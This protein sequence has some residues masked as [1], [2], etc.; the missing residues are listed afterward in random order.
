[1]KELY[2]CLKL[3]HRNESIILFVDQ[4][5]GTEEIPTDLIKAIILK[6]DLP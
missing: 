5:D 1:M 4:S 6:H 3:N 2:D